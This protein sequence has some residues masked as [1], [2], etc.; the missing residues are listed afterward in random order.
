M[1][2]FS[3]LYFPTHLIICLLQKLAVLA[4]LSNVNKII[5][6]SSFTTYCHNSRNTFFF[7]IQGQLLCSFRMGN[8]FREAFFLNSLFF[9]PKY[10]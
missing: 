1:V 9:L 2:A 3:V 6:F 5:L 4:F 8:F 10:T 7:F